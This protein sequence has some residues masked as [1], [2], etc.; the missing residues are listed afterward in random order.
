MSEYRRYLVSA[1]YRCGHHGQ[2]LARALEAGEL[3]LDAGQEESLYRVLQQ[4][5]NDVTTERNK[6]QRFGFR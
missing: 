4:L 5:E 1:L 3:K 6:A 2:R